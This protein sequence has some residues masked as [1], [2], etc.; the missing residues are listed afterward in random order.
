MTVLFL[1]IRLR[2]KG[3]Y[4]AGWTDPSLE[5]ELQDDD[6]QWR[7]DDFQ[8]R[9]DDFQWRNDDFQWRWMFVGLLICITLALIGIWKVGHP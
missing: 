4:R 3:P 2:S 7:N 8:W 9:N 5:Q 6:F 1:A